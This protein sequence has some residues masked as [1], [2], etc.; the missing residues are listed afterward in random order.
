MPTSDSRLDTKGEVG[1]ADDGLHEYLSHTA[2]VASVALP[3]FM[4]EVA[5]VGEFEDTSYDYV[6]DIYSYRITLTSRVV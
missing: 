4:N 2:V 6:M 5:L 3:V 1:S